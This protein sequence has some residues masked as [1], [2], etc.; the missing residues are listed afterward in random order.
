MHKRKTVTHRSSQE[1][2]SPNH[3]HI[4]RH[5]EQSGKTETKLPKLAITGITALWDTT[6]NMSFSQQQL[7]HRSIS[8]CHLPTQIELAF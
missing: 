2:V 1:G 4:L 3:L 7:S 8:V 5:G 6:L